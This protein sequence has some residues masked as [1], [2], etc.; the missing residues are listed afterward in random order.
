MAGSALDKENQRWRKIPKKFHTLEE[1]GDLLKEERPH[2]PGTT[3]DHMFVHDII[4]I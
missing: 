3:L 4:I 2:G 1:D